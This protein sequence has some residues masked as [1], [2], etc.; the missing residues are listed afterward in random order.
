MDVCQYNKSS[1]KG[2]L[3]VSL[4]PPMELQE[5]WDEAKKTMQISN[6]DY[7][8]VIKKLHF[9]YDMK[10]VI[11]GIN[12]E[13]HLILQFPV[14]VQACTQQQLILYQVETVPVPIID[15]N[16]Q[17]HSYIHLQEVSPI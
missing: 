5:I 8:V 13:R 14:F 16:K 1:V 6:P 2:Y 3:P 9:H 10:L 17:A 15:Q 11:F 7:D 12:E 4:L